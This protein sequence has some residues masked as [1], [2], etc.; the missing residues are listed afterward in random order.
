MSKN[1]SFPEVS[2][3]ELRWR[4]DPRSFP[5][6]T[7]DE[8]DPLK[9][10]IGQDRAMEAFRFG[11]GVRKKSYHLFVTGPTGTG[12]MTT[13]LKI[14]EE[15]AQKDRIPDDLCYVYNFKN[16]ESPRLIRFKAGLGRKFKTDIHDFI[17]ALKK[18]VP[19]LFESEDYLNM[20]KEI[21]EK[22]E[23]RG[24]QFFKELDNRVK[25]EGFAV[26]QMQVGQVT[27]PVVMPIVNEQPTPMEKLEVLVEKGEYP[28][29]KFETI[30]TKH[31]QLTERVDRI[32]LEIRDMQREVQKKLEDMDREIFLRSISGPVHELKE[33]YDQPKVH[34]YVDEMTE[35]LAENL[36]V[37]RAGPQQQSMPGFPLNPFGQGN[38]FQ[39]Y[40]VNLLVDNAETEHQPIVVENYPNYKN[41]FGSIER[42][43][44]RSG[45]WTTDYSRIHAGSLVK[46]NG[47]FLVLNLLDAVLEPGVWPG[48]KRALKSNLVEVQTF[49]PYYLFTS[50]GMTP[51]PIELDLKVVVIGDSYLYYLLNAHDQDVRKIFKVRADFAGSMKKDEEAVN[52]VAR[53][54][55]LKCDEDHLKPFDRSAVAAV[56]EEAVRM[57]GRQEKLTTHL[58]RLTE[59]LVEA[60]FR[61]QADGKS[62]VSASHV[63]KALEARIYRSSLIEEQIQE[64]IDRGSILIDTEGDVVGQVNGL[65]VYSL[66]D[67]S[68]GKP[69]RITAV[70][71]MGR[72]G[73]INIEREADLSGSTHNKGVLILSGYLRKKYAQ[74]KPLSMTASLAFEQS[75]S[76]VD[77]DSASSTEIYA[78]LSSLSNVPLRQDLAVTGSV[79]QKGE[80]QAIGGVNQKIEGFF[81]CCKAKG[82]TGTQGVLIPQSNVQDLMLRKHIVEAVEQGQFHIY[83]VKTVDQGIEILTGV[84]AGE[85]DAEGKY[86]E[87]SINFLV[88]RK[89][90]DLA[91]GLK[92]FGE[93]EEKEDRKKASQKGGCC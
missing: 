81:E 33:K 39:P 77:G 32:F 17:E 40:Q 30:K 31:R 24:R 52:H 57:A 82:L 36:G 51:E 65:S 86:P 47:G 4:L 68:F 20:K 13:V 2:V 44:D 67:Y 89:L 12:R 45:V 23:D 87:G 37:F 29:E 60:D 93:G 90:S 10:I 21:L 49:D 25:E 3:E 66:P 7:T 61:A 70:T 75:Y 76:G 71:S 48:L 78:I 54:I 92:E 14:L 58:L 53:Y 18:D 69:T 8:L 11:L 80:I 62:V 72:A 91:K 19:Q 38:P 26:V 15:M 5:F 9:E 55:K 88:D 74:E 50:T 59:I 27:R 34:T 64:M 63:E 22:Y 1:L 73:V 83:P 35:D 85:P 41:I 42:V 6:E 79:N 46:A 16:P 28:K 84:P 56:V 43:V